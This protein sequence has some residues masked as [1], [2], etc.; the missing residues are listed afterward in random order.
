MPHDYIASYDHY[1]RTRHD[2]NVCQEI[3]F[4]SKATTFSGLLKSFSKLMDSG[5]DADIDGLPYFQQVS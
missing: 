4:T 3:R 1:D 5:Y 2:W